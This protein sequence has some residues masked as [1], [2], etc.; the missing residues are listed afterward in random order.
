MQFVASVVVLQ[1]VCAPVETVN[2]V[3]EDCTESASEP[4]PALYASTKG[5]A[6]LPPTAMETGPTAVFVRRSIG[7]A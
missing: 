1:A 5:A 4:S 3:A 2:Q 6:A 7:A